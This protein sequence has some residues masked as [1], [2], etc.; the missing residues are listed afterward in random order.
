M[1][2]SIILGVFVLAG[3]FAGSFL[4]GRVSGEVRSNWAD[5][6]ETTVP[7]TL[8]FSQNWTNTAL[9]TTDDA[10]TG[11]PGIVGYRGDDAAAGSDVDIRTV[12]QD[13]TSSPVDVNANRNDPDAFATGGIAEFDGIPNP[14]VAM[15]GSGTADFPNLVIYLNTTGRSNINITFNARDI[16]AG[17]DV[18]QQLNVQYR[19]GSSGTYA[20][21]AGG[22]FA[23][24][25]AA[26]ATMV[27]AINLTLP[28]DA[29]NQP[30]LEI[31]IM[32]ANAT[33]SDEFIGIDDINVTG[34]G[35]GTPTPT[36]TPGT[37]RKFE[38]SL[39]GSNEVPPNASTASGYGRVVLNAA[40]TQVTASFYYNNLSS[41]TNGGHIHTPG[42][43]GVNAPIVFNMT[44]T[45]G[46][47]NGSVVDKVFT[48][49]P[50]QVANLKA[51]LWYFNVHTT[52]FPDGEIRGQILAADA[53]AD[54]NG[55][56]KTDY[57]VVRNAGGPSGQLTWY[58]LLNGGS[59]SQT[60]WGIATDTIAHGDFDGDGRDDIAI[61]RPGAALTAGFHILQSSTGTLRFDQFGQIGDI[62]VVADYSGDGK[63][64]PAIY[65]PGATSNSQSST[66]N[67]PS[68]G[69]LAGQPVQT[70]WGLGSDTPVTG[71]F[72]GDG[73]ADFAVQR[74][75]GGGQAV[76]LI[77]PGTGA[78]DAPGA[79]T[80]VLFGLTTDAIVSGDYD[81]DGKTDIAVVR[82]EG[83]QLVWYSL[84]SNGGATV[85]RPWGLANDVLVP[86]DYDGDGLND[87]AVWR[88]N[89]DPTQNF[90]FVLGSSG[91]ASQTE[92]GQTGDIPVANDSVR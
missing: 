67:R 11:V 80:A 71:D 59:N 8:P 63:D 90:F 65:R 44:P 73:K 23:D 86:G 54:S 41:G 22:Y 92:W 31:R 16:D 38:A 17:S 18:V 2:R 66:W 60:P 85:V 12:T 19:N 50:A 25:T 43:P 29:N 56:G 48:V 26:G 21:I 39:R 52:S 61:W 36:P 78:G 47:T 24:A 75:A 72:N 64:D 70:N 57:S 3:I 14:V 33:G 30:V 13:L 87:Y 40:E 62:P 84:Q 83:G 27:T 10:W 9:I 88:R 76:F 82:T 89:A 37:P 32:T 45:A 34:T 28:P 1:K 5:G 42:A 68:S 51:G 55:D 49:T 20:N 53:P 58:T 35:G 15:Q 69:T 81:G 77:H 7:Q 79:D 91:A 46:Q 6:T 74:N 4:I